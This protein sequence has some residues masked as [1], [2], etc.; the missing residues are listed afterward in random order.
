MNIVSCMKDHKGSMS[1]VEVKS[2]KDKYTI[3]TI[4]YPLWFSVLYKVYTVIY[5]ML[6]FNNKQ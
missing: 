4:L 6:L 2:Q 5:K 1:F 3:K